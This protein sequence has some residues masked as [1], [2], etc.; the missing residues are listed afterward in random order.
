M[1]EKQARVA[2]GVSRRA[3]RTTGLKKKRRSGIRALL[4]I[5]EGDQRGDTNGVN[6]E[7]LGD[8]R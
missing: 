2:S 3:Q 4:N 8:T 1:V 7:P 5:D 6:P